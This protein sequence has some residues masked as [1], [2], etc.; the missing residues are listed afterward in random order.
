MSEGVPKLRDTIAVHTVFVP[1]LV[2]G[3]I[4]VGIST[5][6][7]GTTTSTVL[8]AQ[9][10]ATANSEAIDAKCTAD[11]SYD[12]NYPFYDTHTGQLCG[13]GK[14]VSS[15]QV[16]GHCASEGNATVDCVMTEAG[17]CVQPQSANSTQ[18][19]GEPQPGVTYNGAFYPIESTQAPPSYETSDL[20]TFGA[21][22]SGQLESN[23]LL[24]PQ[25]NDIGQVGYSQE[26][27][28]SSLPGSPASVQTVSVSA[29]YPPGAEFMPSENNPSVST[30]GA[31][32]GQFDDIASPLS[33]NEEQAGVFNSYSNYD[34]SSQSNPLT[35]FLPI[36]DSNSGPNIDQEF[37]QFDISPAQTV[38][39]RWPDLG[40]RLTMDGVQP[41]TNVE[42]DRNLPAFLQ[43]AYNQAAQQYPE[44]QDPYSD[45]DFYNKFYDSAGFPQQTVSTSNG[46][47]STGVLQQIWSTLTGLFK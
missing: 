2:L 24:S 28:G 32:A 18:Q 42:D 43:T 30:F 40:D 33:S 4:A 17:N 29:S 46:G 8:L 39:D 23:S 45:P 7:P 9:A 1:I 10:A 47:G 22:S 31:S 6:T 20:S 34:I 36:S 21:P 13:R 44:D 25:P 27:D 16:I 26:F 35:Y 5:L 14:K 3:F 37:D 11:Y 38:A 19:T 15:S 41:S 12:C